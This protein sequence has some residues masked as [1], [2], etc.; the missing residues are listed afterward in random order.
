MTLVLVTN[1]LNEKNYCLT[2]DEAVELVRKHRTEG[3]NPCHL[4]KNLE[5]INGQLDYY[6]KHPEQLDEKTRA[7]MEFFFRFLNDAN[8]REKRK[9]KEIPYV[10]SSI[11]GAGFIERLP[12]IE[13]GQEKSVRVFENARVIWLENMDEIEEEPIEG[14]SYQGYR[15]L[16]K[17]F[18]KWEDTSALSKELDIRLLVEYFRGPLI[19]RRGWFSTSSMIDYAPLR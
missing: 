2:L 17:C 12:I 7:Y 6:K 5:S 18:G 11:L 4:H 14:Y 10:A 15:S 9:R 1:N 3:I 13:R 19:G 16:V 8:H